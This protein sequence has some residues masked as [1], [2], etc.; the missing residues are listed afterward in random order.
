MK[1]LLESIQE[2]ILDTTDKDLDDA[3]WSVVITNKLE[4]SALN[5]L[6]ENGIECT[7][8]D[9]SEKPKL[10]SCFVEY[11]RH[12]HEMELTGDSGLSMNNNFIK[13]SLN[14]GK[15]YTITYVKDYDCLKL[16]LLDDFDRPIICTDC[17]LKDIPT[18]LKGNFFQSFATYYNRW[19]KRNTK[20]LNE[21]EF[22]IK[23]INNTIK[24]I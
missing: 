14:D 20:E 19:I 11:Y 23:C 9:D 13:F 10:L 2:S 7:L 4:R 16:I 21:L 8:V 15:N 3:T 6:K 12:S 17:R 18:I 5:T 24:K 1:S 22:R